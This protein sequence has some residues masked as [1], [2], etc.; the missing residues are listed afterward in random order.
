M[1]LYDDSY[2]Y[3]SLVAGVLAS[4]GPGQDFN[5]EGFQEAISGVAL[6]CVIDLHFWEAL[7]KLFANPDEFIANLFGG[8]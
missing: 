7:A 4:C 5:P 1:V 8:Q 2:E 3:C 6:Y